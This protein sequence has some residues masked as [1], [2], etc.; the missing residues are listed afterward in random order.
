MG[1]PRVPTRTVLFQSERSGLTY[2]VPALLPVTPGPTLLAF[3]EQRLSPNDAHAHRLVQRCGT[4]AGGS[5]RVSDLAGGG[6][7]R[8]GRETEAAPA[9][10][11]PPSRQWGAAQVLG[12]AALEEHRSMNPCPV[13]DARTGTVF[14]FFVAVRGQT[15]EVAQIATGRNAARLCCVTSRDAGR[16]WGSARDLTAEAVGAT[17]RGRRAQAPV[18]TR[19]RACTGWGGSSPLV[20]A[21][22]ASGPSAARPRPQPKDPGGCTILHPRVRKRVLATPE[23]AVC[24][25]S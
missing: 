22:L 9:L 3:A 7:A 21:G 23:G 8:C 13:H 20:G 24:S 12:S 1:T 2:R 19:G 25:S 18:Y 5:V 6:G 15:P 17:E 14:L 4:L 10:T 16:T 11:P